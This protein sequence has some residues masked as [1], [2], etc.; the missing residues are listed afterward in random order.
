MCAVCFLKLLFFFIFERRSQT[1]Y[2]TVAAGGD[3]WYG[4]PYHSKYIPRP[5]QRAGVDGGGRGLAGGLDIGGGG[6]G[7]LGSGMM[8]AGGQTTRK[9]K[10]RGRG[11]T[12]RWR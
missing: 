10:E 8:M 12:G 4:N 6:S 7:G 9:V 5:V 1:K 11:A 2:T 3:Q